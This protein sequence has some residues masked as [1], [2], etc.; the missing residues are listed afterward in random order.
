MSEKT[1]APEVLEDY[2]TKPV[3]ENKQM[4]W[5]SQGMV[6]AGSAFCLVAF[7]VGGMLASAMSFGS[8]LLAVLIGSAIL[9]A[10]ASSIGVIGA[11]THLASAFTSRFT[12]G[13]G[14]SKIFGLIIALSLFGWFGDQCSSFGL[15][16]VATFALF[17]VSAGS[18]AL[19][20][21]IGGIAMMI[22]AVVGYKGIKFLSNFGVP[23]LF[24]L[25]FIAAIITAVKVP[26]ANLAA[27]SVAA[28][29]HM[30][31]PA[32]ITAVV[33]S[34]ISGA[35]TIPDFSR[36][37][38]YPKD[39]TNGCVLGFMISFP[40]I[41][42][43]GGFFFYAYSTADLCS[44]FITQ[45][46][47]GV[48]AAFV[49]IVS[50]W[51][52]NDNNLYSSVLGITNALGEK[53]KMPRWLLTVIVGVISTILGTLG[54]MDHLTSFLNILG[55]CIPPIAA[56]I[57]CDY[58]AYNKNTGLYSYENVKKIPLFR[59]NTCVAAL[60]GIAI[61]L[62]CNY[63]GIFAAVLAFVPACLVA[64]AASALALVII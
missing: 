10:I 63:T 15:S 5:F 30:S 9:C 11:K 61:G 23:L 45:C 35:C 20:S 7:S 1:K 16:A 27:A 57:I 59:V 8:F 58:Y 43:L 60:I 19:W 55:V 14:G 49:L 64:M 21:V 18:V 44:F 24:I 37:S 62:L 53:L 4:R 42:L 12:L 52:T 25:V 38:K 29:G 47:L 46:G 26:G 39:A 34:F 31:I 41:L 13:T 33:G 3:P 36:F 48:F 50:T 22:T 40:I 51:T 56:A 17:T 54:I 28:A 2:E 6:W 32:A